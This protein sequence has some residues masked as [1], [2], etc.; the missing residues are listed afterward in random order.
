MDSAVVPAVGDDGPQQ[1]G[2]IVLPTITDEFMMFDAL[3]GPSNPSVQQN[4][5]Q[6]KTTK[7]TRKGARKREGGTERN[8][9]S[10]T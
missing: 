2:I 5:R 9:M 4:R 1:V 7:R 8:D 6:T 10:F 3:F